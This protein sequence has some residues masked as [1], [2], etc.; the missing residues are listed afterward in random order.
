MGIWSRL[1]LLRG[2]TCPSRELQTSPVACAS[3]ALSSQTVS[4]NS[5]V[6]RKLKVSS[7]CQFARMC[8]VYVPSVYRFRIKK[9][10]DAI[11]PGTPKLFNTPILRGSERSGDTL[12]MF[13]TLAPRNTIQQIQWQSV[14]LTSVPTVAC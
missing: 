4:V 10:V 1:T 7:I 3:L 9:R 13:W 8:I 2:D 12:L 14:N 11:L 5:L 6:N